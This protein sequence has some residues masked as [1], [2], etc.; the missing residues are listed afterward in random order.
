MQPNDQRNCPAIQRCS[1][2]QEAC[3]EQRPEKPPYCSSDLRRRASGCSDR[4][5]HHDVRRCRRETGQQ[6]SRA[7]YDC[8]SPSPSATRHSAGRACSK[9]AL[10]YLFKFSDAIVIKST[11][12]K[13]LHDAATNTGQ[14]NLV[15]A[16]ISA[17]R[18]I[19]CCPRTIGGTVADHEGSLLSAMVPISFRGAND[20]FQ[21]G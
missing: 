6:R 15:L 2:A 9:L 7:R 14:P 17:G 4:G 21:G 12:S 18:F 8:P 3:H 13:W 19:W 11:L 10:R 1:L 20:A 5:L 16:S